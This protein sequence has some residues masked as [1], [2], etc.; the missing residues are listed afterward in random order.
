VPVTDV[1]PPARLLVDTGLIEMDVQL[2]IQR[3]LQHSAGNP[4]QQPTRPD[5]GT[6]SALARSTSCRANSS[7]AGVDRGS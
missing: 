1:G 3:R 7:S 6:P 5:Q 2:R 4:G